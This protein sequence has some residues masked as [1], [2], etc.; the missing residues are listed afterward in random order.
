[1]I[2]VLPCTMSRKWI[3]PLFCRPALAVHYITSM[4]AISLSPFR[5]VPWLIRDHFNFMLSH[6][7]LPC[8]SRSLH[9]WIIRLCFF[10]FQLLS[11]RAAPRLGMWGEKVNSCGW[12]RKRQTEKEAVSKH[13]FHL[14]NTGTWS[15]EANCVDQRTKEFSQTWLNWSRPWQPVSVSKTRDV[16]LAVRRL[17]KCC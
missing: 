10:S 14:L 16:Q 7:F 9:D 15:P 4:M 12:K 11:E 8:V 17:W 6:W 3:G 2:P 1:M 5:Y 13:S